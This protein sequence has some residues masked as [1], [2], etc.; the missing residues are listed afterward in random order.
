MENSKSSKKSKRTAATVSTPE[1]NKTTREGFRT[2]AAQAF[3]NNPTK[4]IREQ[5]SELLKSHS[6]ENEEI[7]AFYSAIF[8]NFNDEEF[9]EKIG[10]DAAVKQSKIDLLKAVTDL[11]D[12]HKIALLKSLKES[13]YL[14]DL[15]PSEML[16]AIDL[17]DKNLVFE[18]IFEGG[19]GGLSDEEKSN[20]LDIIQICFEEELNEKNEKALDAAKQYIS[21][22]QLETQIKCLKITIPHMGEEEKTQLCKFLL[23]VFADDKTTDEKLGIVKLVGLVSKSGFSV[24]ENFAAIKDDVIALLL[25]DLTTQ[26]FNKKL[27]PESQKSHDD[28]KDLISSN[29][30]DIS[31]QTIFKSLQAKS[32]KEI[33]E[34][35]NGGLDKSFADQFK[36][37]LKA[38]LNFFL[39]LA[40]REQYL[41]SASKECSNFAEL[42]A[43]KQASVGLSVA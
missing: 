6:K 40:G 30:F 24:D 27:S 32:L 11:D 17:Y 16:N 20:L 8:Q 22:S 10:D 31:Q 13:G 35:F 33:L 43:S 25:V 12:E 28:I 41:Y 37:F 19:L 2:L 42:I 3:A 1:R 9:K 4:Y 18:S 7:I 29:G 14:D 21:T 34:Y 23:E 36:D 39:K 26:A 15:K 5:L 38:V